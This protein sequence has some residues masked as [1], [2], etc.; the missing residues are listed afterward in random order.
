MFVV[1]EH[2]TTQAAGVPPAERGRH[3]DLLVEDPGR[4]R[5]PTWRLARDP[6]GATG[7]IPAERI[8]D[9]R[10]L[11][12]DYEGEVS[13]DRG[14]VRRL[15]RGPATIECLEADHVIVAL[16]GERLRGRFEI[17][18]PPSGPTVFRR[19]PGASS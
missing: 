3:W 4:E 12:L 5:L 6:L 14:V 2:D 19:A 7:E 13:G 18:R 15:D 10:R 17:I 11:Y 9:H 16:N 8:Q 1:L